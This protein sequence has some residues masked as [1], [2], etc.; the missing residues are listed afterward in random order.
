MSVQRTP[1]K[2]PVLDPCLE[3]NLKTCYMVWRHLLHK[4]KDYR[5]K[6]L[7]ALA[8]YENAEAASLLGEPMRVRGAVR[9][10]ICAGCHIFE[11]EKTCGNCRRCASSSGCE[12]HHRCC[13]KWSRAM[14]TDH[15]GSS[16]TA[17]SS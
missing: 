14:C 16:I 7:H 3:E 13:E 6:V 8:R 10:K 15:G 5:V 1:P 11:Q 4:A 2:E 17:I 12:G 9:Y